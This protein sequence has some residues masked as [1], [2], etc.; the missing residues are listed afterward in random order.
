MREFESA[1]GLPR[2]LQ[3][4]KDNE[5]VVVTNS[6]KIKDDYPEEY[7]VYE[8]VRAK[9]LLAVPVKPRPVGFLVVRHPQRYGTDCR[10]SVSYTHLRA[11]PKRSIYLS[12]E[13]NRKE[14]FLPIGKTALYRNYG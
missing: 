1:S 8:R 14:W 3:A 6:K 7:T 11:Q 13:Q 10:M 4:M 12:A 9:S 5:P 2:W